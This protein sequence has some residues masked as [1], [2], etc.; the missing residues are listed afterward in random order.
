M[1]AH[2]QP[3]RARRAIPAHELA[4]VAS[5][6]IG[7]GAHEGFAGHGLS[8]MPLEIQVHAAPEAVHAQQRLQH[9]D[10]LRAF[11]VHGG[12]VEIVDGLI[13][14]RADRVAH[15][16]GILGKL[17]LSQQPH[18]VHALQ[19]THAAGGLRIHAG[20]HLIGREFL[21]AEYRQPF[22]QRQLEPVAAGDA[23]ARPVVEI[24]VTDDRFDPLEIGIGGHERIGK[25]VLG[26]EDVQ[27]L[28][29]HGAHVEIR[30][31]HDHEPV[32]I[33]L[34]PEAP[35]VPGNSFFQALQRKAG[36]VNLLRPGP[37]LQQHLA[38]RGQ[39]VAGFVHRQLPGHQRKQ[40][41][42]LAE[43]ILPN[44]LVPFGTG[45]SIPAA[46][47][48]ATGTGTSTSTSTSTSTTGGRISSRTSNRATRTTTSAGRTC[49]RGRPAG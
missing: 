47:A 27:P 2:H 6:G 44:D 36:A 23:V 29:F 35:L 20:G 18:V 28:V 49:Q 32:Q 34:Q 37:H 38:P 9:P 16:A 21:V 14:V 45:R 40:V 43:R 5:V 3:R 30:G 8:V 10:H 33:Q 4:Q 7:H 19:G 12:G 15:W 17:H 1:A 25:H 48:T 46:T 13:A 42:G 41:A 11:F 26:V 39:P 22:L 31:R 24:L